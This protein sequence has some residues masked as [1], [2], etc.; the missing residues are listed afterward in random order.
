MKKVILLVPAALC[1]AFTIPVQGHSNAGRMAEEPDTVVVVD[2]AMTD[3]ID[4]DYF[5]DS[6]WAGSDVPDDSVA[7]D[8]LDEGFCSYNDELLKTPTIRCKTLLMPMQAQRLVPRS[9]LL[10]PTR[11]VKCERARDIAS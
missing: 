11:M 1:L 4:D 8:S 6:D 5:E 9:S 3:S 2:S 10:M 7:V